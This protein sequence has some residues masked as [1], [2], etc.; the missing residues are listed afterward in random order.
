MNHTILP[1][2]LSFDFWTVH[3]VFGVLRDYN[4]AGFLSAKLEGTGELPLSKL[5]LTACGIVVSN[6]ERKDHLPTPLQDLK[7]PVSTC[8]MR[9]TSKD[10]RTDVWERVSIVVNH[11]TSTGVDRCVSHH[12][13]KNISKQQACSSSF[14]QGC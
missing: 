7:S 1:T 12:S 2:L 5:T 8:H 6:L 11:S 10:Q 3:G 4:L 14:N 9:G 13:S